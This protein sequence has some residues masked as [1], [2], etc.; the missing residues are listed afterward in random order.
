[1][2]EFQIRALTAS[3]QVLTQLSEL[4]IEWSPMGVR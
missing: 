2:S 3:M 4:L 1:M